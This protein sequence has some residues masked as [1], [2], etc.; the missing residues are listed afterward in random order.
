VPGLATGASSLEELDEKLAVAVP[1]LLAENG[2]PFEAEKSPL[3]IEV[4][5]RRTS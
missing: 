3:E 1:E 2:I 4:Q 5:H